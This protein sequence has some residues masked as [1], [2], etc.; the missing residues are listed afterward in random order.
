MRAPRLRSAGFTLIE[1]VISFAILLVLALAIASAFLPI[2]TA[3]T[4][5]NVDLDLDRNA[6]RVLAELRREVRQTGMGNGVDKLTVPADNVTITTPTPPTAATATTLLTYEMRTGPDAATDWRGPITIRAV[7]D[8]T[9]SNVPANSV[10]RYRLERVEGTQTVVI[11]RNVSR[12]SVNRPAGGKTVTVTI[13]MSRPDPHR[14]DPNVVPPPITQ[15]HT[16]QIEFL[17]Q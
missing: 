6:R 7:P 9:Y 14:A 12:V 11:A 10:N 4:R 3:T 2:E 15:S 1:I 16:D 5:S 8:G 17:N 13:D